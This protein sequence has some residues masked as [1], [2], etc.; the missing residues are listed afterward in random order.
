MD[1]PVPPRV[2]ELL[3]RV[4]SFV[5]ERIQPLE[6]RLDEDWS[7][8]AT[9]LEGIRD[10]VRRRGWWAPFLAREHGGM[11][12]GLTEFAFLSEEL[13]RTPLGHYAFHCQAPAVAR[14]RTGETGRSSPSWVPRSRSGPGWCR[15]PGGRSAAASPC[16]SGNGPAPTPP[17]WAPPPASRETSG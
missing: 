10:E 5:E 13:G 16:P 12:L 14:R 8:L 11:G 3:P 17:G 6:R 2:A 9:E 7:V 15:S 1:F 4:R